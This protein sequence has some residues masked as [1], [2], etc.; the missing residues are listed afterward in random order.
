MPRMRSPHRFS[1]LSFHRSVIGRLARDQHMN[2]TEE[3]KM[4]GIAV[5]IGSARSSDLWKS[6]P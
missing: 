6:R 5:P 1:K 3:P 2:W 4:A